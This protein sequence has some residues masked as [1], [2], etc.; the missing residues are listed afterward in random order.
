MFSFLSGRLH[1]K[2]IVAFVLILL[3]PTG[4]ISYYNVRITSATLIQ[5]IGTEE[6]NDLVGQANNMERRLIDFRDD[7]IFLS[8]AP[9]TRHYAE[10]INGQDDL[11]STARDAQILL[12]KT[13]LDRAANQYRDIRLIDLSGQELIRVD[14][15][16]NVLPPDNNGMNQAGQAYFN[17][18]IGL[19]S[20]QV[21]ISDFDLNRTNGLIDRPYV[22]ILY[23]SIPIQADG[24]TVAVLVAKVLL[25][26]FFKDMLAR[27]PTSIFLVNRDGSYLL[28][29]DPQK[30][31]GKILKTGITFDAER[32]RQDVIEMFGKDQ[33]LIEHSPDFTDTLQ[34][35]V[36][37]KPETQIGVRWLLIR[38]VPLSTILSEVN[39]TQSLAI[40]LSLL[41]LL[42]AI[43]VGILLTRGIVRPIQQLANVADAVRQGTWD[44]TVPYTGM[45]DEIGHLAGAFDRMLRELKS[46]Y[47]NLE[48][49]VA[50]RTAEL[51]AANIKLSEA[52][53]KTEEA[54]RAKSLFLSNMSHELRTPLNVIVGYAHAMLA[55][56]QMFND[57]MLPEVFRPYVKLIEDNGHY[58]IG[59]I[60]DIL[61]LS[62]IE[63]GKLELICST[64]ELTEIFRGVLATATGLLKDKPVQIRPDYPEDLP[65]V[66][67]DA[68]R[69]RQIVL[70][71]F[72]NAVKFTTTG[73]ITLKAEVCDAWVKISVI[74]TGIGIPE[75]AQA[76]IFSRFGQ[77]SGL[78][79]REAEGTGLGLD[80]SKQLSQM[81]GG[82]LTFTSVPG[83]GSSFTF[84]LP[85]ASENQV[86]SARSIEPTSEAFMIFNQSELDTSNVYSVLLVE[87]E[88]SMREMLRRTLENAG[89]LV[90][91]THDGAQVL[92]LAVGMLPN[93]IILD[94]TLPHLNGWELMQQL[95]IDPATQHI[96]VIIYTASSEEERAH[97]LGAAAYIR[98][99]APLDSILTAIRDV[100][101]I[102]DPLPDSFIAASVESEEE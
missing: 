73:S 76:L 4:I 97:A 51:E 101:H 77:V 19:A 71:L 24:S 95:R 81:H 62:K 70:N 20:N 88:V 68:R 60:N 82:D 49:R 100:L 33:G 2:L 23:Y 17:Q 84:T 85:V 14:A 55:M 94:V 57:A 74:D 1:N 13:F 87:D 18:A 15:N 5:K 90:V 52:Q 40:S 35:F 31:Y 11:N 66:W 78:N 80:I 27:S 99:P 102:P 59:L 91:D 36:R 47:G 10:V 86:L 39:N 79:H 12:F 28:N 29:P 21:Y 37:I 69:V 38:N 25:D 48:T 34:V 72:S 96:P 45:K 56:P 46:V 9:P 63:A 92:Q 53:R 41:S 83:K 64:V 67:A 44:V 42:I 98:K 8:Q 50:S 16:G 22:P 6:L 58:L 89:Y 7:L 43:V 75:E 32:S 3:I 54:S 93:I 61:D 65:L 26:P 30:L